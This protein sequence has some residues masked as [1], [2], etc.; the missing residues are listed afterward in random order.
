MREFGWVRVTDGAKCRCL[1]LQACRAALP[2]RR[3]PEPPK[4]PDRSPSGTSLKPAERLYAR[5]LERGTPQQHPK[6]NSHALRARARAGCAGPA[7][8]SR[9]REGVNFRPAH[10]GQ[11]STGLDTRTRSEG[12]G[13]SP[14][15][16][17]HASH[18]PDAEDMLAAEAER[19]PHPRRP[20]ATGSRLGRSAVQHVIFE[21]S[22]LH[23]SREGR[24][25]SAPG[26]S[27]PRIAGGSARRRAA[28]LVQLG[29]DQRGARATRPPKRSPF[30]RG[31][32]RS[33]LQ[34]VPASIPVVGSGTS[35]PTS[36]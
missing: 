36:G 10:R 29:L 7:S 6:Q 1:G 21:V 34:S 2:A 15:T 19:F 5:R 16:V 3:P 31:S 20:A 26:G 35:A 33:V 11:L 22:L 4:R 32:E 9:S 13:H 23:M 14:R 17:R 8:P 12:H 30:C 25:G 24:R 27:D 28:E 18:S